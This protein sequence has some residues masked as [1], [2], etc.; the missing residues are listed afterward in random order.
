MEQW[1]YCKFIA[2]VIDPGL[3][4]HQAPCAWVSGSLEISYATAS[5]KIVAFIEK[6][7]GKNRTIKENYMS[8]TRNA[9]KKLN[10]LAR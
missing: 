8:E 3:K 1:C 9:R 10:W 5:H 4:A 2:L 6:Q 7:R